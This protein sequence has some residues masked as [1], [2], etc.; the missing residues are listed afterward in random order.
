MEVEQCFFKG[1]DSPMVATESVNVL[2]GADVPVEVN[3]ILPP[4]I[5]NNHGSG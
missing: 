2:G 4:T 1:S 3:V 5:S